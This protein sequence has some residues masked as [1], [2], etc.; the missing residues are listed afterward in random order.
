MSYYELSVPLHFH[1]KALLW[2]S[3]SQSSRFMKPIWSEPQIPPG[4][5]V[6]P[7]SNRMLIVSQ[8]SQLDGRLRILATSL[9]TFEA[10]FRYA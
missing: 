7:S 3:S 9:T 5:G 6:Q 10:C 4:T 1:A 2:S 8:L